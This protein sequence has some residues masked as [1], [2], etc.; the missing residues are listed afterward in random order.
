[1]DILMKMSTID[2]NPTKD[3]HE[4]REFPAPKKSG[5]AHAQS[6]NKTISDKWNDFRQTGLL[7]FVNMFLHI[8][9]WAITLKIDTDTKEILEVYPQRVKYKGYDVETIDEAYKKVKSFFEAQNSEY[10]EK[11]Y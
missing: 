4:S 7:V 2:K 5:M 8:F 6:K 11:E 9:G 3:L 10:V 1:M